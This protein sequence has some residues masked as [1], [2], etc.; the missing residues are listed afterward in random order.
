M[1]RRILVQQRAH[2]WLRSE[3]LHK[4]RRVALTPLDAKLLLDHGSQVTVERC[5]TRI[6]GDSEYEQVGC[7][8]VDQDGWRGAECESDVVP[9]DAYI[10]GLKEL[11]PLPKSLARA[12]MYFA[13]CFK[14]Q[15][16]WRDE[17]ARFLAGNGR[18][19]DLEFL[20]DANGRR[21]AAFGF[22]AG[23]AGMAVGLAGYYARLDGELQL[24]PLDSFDN[25][26]A[27][28]NYVNGWRKG[29]ALPAG[30]VLGARGAAGQGAAA[31]YRSM[32][33]AF[34]L[35]SHAPL[36]EWD[37]E[38]TADV[39]GSRAALLHDFDLL[40][41]CINLQQ[42]TVPFVSADG[43]A[44]RRLSVVADVSCDPNNPYNPLPIYRDETTFDAPLHT[45]RI[46]DGGKPISVLAISHL[47][48][49]LPREASTHFSEALLP[50]LKNL[51]PEPFAA[52]PLHDI[53]FRSALDS[54]DRA[55]DE[56][57]SQ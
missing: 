46:D 33:G 16:G 15:F 41:N 27:L 11:G 29:R 34:S 28:R 47:P 13:H 23:Y 42:P 54:F 38:E 22:H 56:F 36:A 53:V 20:T 17:M 10:L 52:K 43:A 44:Q 49:L 21:V 45:A 12:H 39:E 51:A 18:L 6:F 25:A 9:H 48:S 1:S 2:V 32:E 14:E 26:D 19:F 30:A 50:H 40:V 7:T 55:V 24:P 57:H 31:F 37:L 35:D 5:S 4:E 8:L 3:T